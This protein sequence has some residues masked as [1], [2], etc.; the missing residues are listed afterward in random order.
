M[1]VRRPAVRR[2][3]LTAAFTSAIESGLTVRSTRFFP[4]GGFALDFGVAEKPA[5]VA[6]QDLE[7]LQLEAKYGEG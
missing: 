4:D 3:E 7:L 2:S 6:D 1:S 5:P